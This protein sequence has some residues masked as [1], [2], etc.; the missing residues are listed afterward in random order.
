MIAFVSGGAGAGGETSDIYA[1]DPDGSDRINITNHP[2][3][4]AA[5]AFS[6]DGRTIAFQ[7]DRDDNSEIYVMAADG[8]NP[9][10]LTNSPAADSEPAF[11]ADGQR[12][13]FQSNRDGNLEIY[14]MATDGSGVVRLTNNAI[15]DS[16]PA[17]SP[18]GRRIAF[19]RAGPVPLNPGNAFSRNEI[20]T[21]ALDGSDQTRLTFDNGDLDPA[22]SPDGLTIAFVRSVFRRHK[23]HTMAADGSGQTNISDSTGTCGEFFFDFHPAFSP[24][25]DRIVFASTRDD[26]SRLCLSGPTRIYTADPDGSNIE[27]LSVEGRQPDWQPL[28]A[29]PGA[30]TPARSPERAA[31]PP[32]PGAPRDKPSLQAGRCAN[33]K[34]GTGASDRLR[35]TV[36]GDGLFGLGGRDLLAGLAGDDCLFGGPGRDRLLGGGG[37]DTLS[38]GTGSDRLAG[39]PGRDRLVGGSGNDTLA[40]GGGRNRYSAGRGRD[41]LIARNRTADRVNCGPG[42]DKATVDPSDRVRGCERV[43]RR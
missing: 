26:P 17:F 5:P 21:M 13:A 32:P 20:W 42:N 43:S 29:P 22:W 25:G 30:T 8:S 33:T 36:A 10:R 2:A 41:T 16:S 6:P 18:D 7:S 23:L 19:V 1:I 11:S 35:G 38:G 24:D 4:D 15:A 12:I 39:G 37:A 40:G 34:R 14:T 3:S 31:S 27:P 9:T 28:D